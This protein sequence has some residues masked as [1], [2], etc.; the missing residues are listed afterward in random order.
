[1]LYHRDKE[2]TSLRENRGA[3]KSK[4]LTEFASVRAADVLLQTQVDLTAA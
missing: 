1:M 2:N 3:R 4:W